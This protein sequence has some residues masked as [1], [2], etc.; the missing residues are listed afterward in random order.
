MLAL[1]CRY[2]DA[3]RVAGRA[4]A[5]VQQGGFP[6]QPAEARSRARLGELLRAAVGER[7]MA[8][9]LDDGALLDEDQAATLALGPGS[10]ATDGALAG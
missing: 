9:L 7:E 6:R 2:R 1:E 8:Q 10:T 5:S 3:A 4:D